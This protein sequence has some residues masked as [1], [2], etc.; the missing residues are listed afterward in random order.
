[1]MDLSDP[2]LIFGWLGGVFRVM[3]LT[4]EQIVL[5]FKKK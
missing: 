1:M 4:C 5:W 3:E 2:I